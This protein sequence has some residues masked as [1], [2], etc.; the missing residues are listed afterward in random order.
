MMKW[1]FMQKVTVTL[2]KYIKSVGVEL[3]ATK[4][5]FK[6]Q[7]SGLD[8]CNISQYMTT[9]RKMRIHY[10]PSFIKGVVDAVELKKCFIKLN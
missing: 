1:I 6:N 2:Q 10:I 9:I 8:K 7:L 4:D 3:W 5:I